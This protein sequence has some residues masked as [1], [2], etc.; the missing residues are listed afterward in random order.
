[1]IIFGINDAH[2]TSTCLFKKSKLIIVVEAIKN[3]ETD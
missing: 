1:M 2:N 3:K